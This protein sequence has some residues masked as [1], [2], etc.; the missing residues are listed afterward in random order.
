MLDNAILCYIYGGSQG[1]LHVYALVGGLAPGSS[2]R[3]PVFVK[4]WAR[5]QEGWAGSKAV[6]ADAASWKKKEYE[7]YSFFTNPMAIE[8]VPC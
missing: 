1:S 6:T 4:V 8:K 7:R 5:G 3:T 2:G